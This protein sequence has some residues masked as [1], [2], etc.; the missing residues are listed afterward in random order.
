[1]LK[2]RKD[3]K[4]RVLR[5]GE[6]ERK[7]GGYQYR[8]E[9]GDRKRHYVYAK[10]L[11]QLRKREKQIEKDNVDGIRLVS[12]K[13]TLNDVY[14]IWEGLKKGLKSNTFNNYKYMYNHFVRNDL[15]QYKIR[16]L[17]VTDIR[18]FYNKLVDV[19]GLKVSSLDTIQLIIHQ[20]LDL[21]VQD[22][23]VRKNV[24]DN[25]LREL[26]R[27]RGIDSIPRK[28]LTIE[29]QNLFLNYL[30]NTDKYKHW[31]PTFAVMLGTGLRVGELTGL[32]WEDID[33]KNNLIKVNH[34][35]VFYERSKS[36]KTG[37][38]IN[39]PKT[40]AGFRTIPMIKTVRE[41]LQKQQTYLQKEQ[42]RSVDNIDGFRDF[43]FLNRFGHVQNQGPLNKALKRII[44]DCNFA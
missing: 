26:K 28:S 29:Q 36:S 31:Y 40:K 4:N 13:M 8:W 33:F 3:S 38:G 16:T 37:F 25:G 24:S 44:R 23:L 43:I 6:T 7:S 9:S 2:R 19:R 20:V 5:S 39:T 34:T 14:D 11:D 18:R 41:A 10:T 1:M 42:I 32:R 30:Q 17:K 15:G 12:M 35:L 21:A 22:D 27:M